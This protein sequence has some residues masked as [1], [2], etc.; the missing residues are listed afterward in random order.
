MPKV[1]KLNHAYANRTKCERE[2]GDLVVSPIKEKN[3]KRKKQSQSV[4]QQ[5]KRVQYTKTKN[6]SDKITANSRLFVCAHVC[7][8]AKGICVVLQEL[9]FLFI[10]LFVM[11]QDP[12]IKRH[13]CTHDR[14]ERHCM[15][16]KHS[17]HNRAYIIYIK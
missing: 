15:K 1:M 3:Q 14:C 5:G 16:R 6:V 17:H 10:F 4:V 7:A 2:C 8:I 12:R 9:S 13:T 11:Y